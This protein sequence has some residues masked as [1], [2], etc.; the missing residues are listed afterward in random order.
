MVTGW[1]ESV[2]ISNER[3]TDDVTIRVSV[4][5]WSAGNGTGSFLSDLFQWSFLIA[6][7][8]ILSFEVEFV[9]TIGVS[10]HVGRE[11]SNVGFLFLQNVWSGRGQSQD[12]D[13]DNLENIA[14]D[15][16]DFMKDSTL[17]L[18]TSFIL[19]ERQWYSYNEWWV[20]AWQELSTLRFICS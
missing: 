2:F 9:G 11:N 15:F 20:Y 12:S 13:K 1:L 6:F 18:F 14:Y 5:I 7:N 8:T 16:G 4:R 17:N 3:Q 19:M 10:I